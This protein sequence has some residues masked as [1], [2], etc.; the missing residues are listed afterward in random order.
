MTTYTLSEARAN[1]SALLDSVERGEEVRIT[2]HGRLAAQLV[3]P[4]A[5]TAGTT[6]L[7]SDVE[8][9]KADLHVASTRPLEPAL[10][11]DADAH[12]KAVRAGRDA[13]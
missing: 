4:R 10:E 3:A 2:R 8:R 1:L 7:W 12:V 9:L 6:R 13:G 11:Y 5:V